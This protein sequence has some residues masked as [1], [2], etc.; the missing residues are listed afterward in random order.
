MMSKLSSWIFPALAVS[1][2]LLFTPIGGYA[3]LIFCMLLAIPAFKLLAG[4][5]DD[6]IEVS[7]YGDLTHWRDMS[8]KAIGF[9]AAVGLIFGLQYIMPPMPGSGSSDCE[10]S[11]SRSGFSRQCLDTVP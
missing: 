9:L 3:N 1:A 4:L 10:S 6:L 5:F 11:V 8:L 2:L 7:S